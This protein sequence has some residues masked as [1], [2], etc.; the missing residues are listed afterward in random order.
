[1]R[2]LRC[3][4]ITPNVRP[5]AELDFDNLDDW[6]IVIESPLVRWQGPL[7][8]AGLDAWTPSVQVGKI[9]LKIVA[10]TDLA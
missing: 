2:V 4:P 8:R 1:M 5:G 6:V 10:G 3:V 9:V 7:S